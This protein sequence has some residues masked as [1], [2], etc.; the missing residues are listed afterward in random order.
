MRLNKLRLNTLMNRALMAGVA[1]L[2]I[3]TPVH[4]QRAK[5]T[6]RLA[7]ND[8]IQGVSYYQDPKVETV[9]TS[10]AV[11]DGL[12]A[13]DE[14]R[15]TFEPLLAK[16]WRRIDP[17]TLEFDLR[18]D[19]KW[20]DGA[21]FSA[22]DVVYT[23]T[24]L[25]DPGTRLRFKHFWSFIKSVEKLGPHKVRMTMHRPTPY[26]L[27][28]LAYQT[29][30]LPAHSHGKAENKVV[31]GQKPVGTGMYRVTRFDQKFGLLLEKNPDYKHGGPAKPASNI[32]RIHIRAITDVGTRVA[33]LMA[34]QI[35]VLSGQTPLDQ[36]DALASLPQFELTAATGIG[37]IYFAIDAKGRAG[38]KALTDP[39]VR[40][41]MMMAIN[42]PQI[43]KLST[44]G[45]PGIENPGAMCWRFQAG[46]DYS[47]TP[48]KFNLDEARKLMRE[49][50][51]GD[52]FETNITSFS[53]INFTQ[54]AD[55]VAGQL[56]QIG[57]RAEIDSMPVGAYRKKQAAGKIQLFVSGWPSGGMPDAAQ[58]I[59][60]LFA[61]P[62]ATDYHGDA[63]MKALAQKSLE[64]MDP[65]ERQK[66]GK[67]IFDLAIERH[68]FL[69]LASSPVFAVHTPEVAITPSKVSSYG[70]NFWG[71]NWKK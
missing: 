40:K 36:I 22:D 7:F 16:S 35:D 15:G 44:G 19:V 42:K 25:T 60:F 49:A 8:S 48:P 47:L 12:I 56:R 11:Y 46:C 31:W 57:I 63:Q 26:D 66:L 43:A 21:P 70:L 18:D 64:E 33:E 37:M 34:G 14:N 5:D 65:V 24:W 38:L 54:M 39:R 28:Q 62:D 27:A 59:A 41:A 61:P 2:L 9:F 53:N 3:Q 13:Y 10:A 23:F 29:A 51:Y 6:L 55:A 20:H 17:V 1:A 69:P 32:G 68:Y 45:R 52:G 67:R 58:T 50:G 71:I 4:A 30:I